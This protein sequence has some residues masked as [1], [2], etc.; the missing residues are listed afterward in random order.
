MAQN[1]LSFG[2][3][4]TIPDQRRVY[5]NFCILRY[6]LIQIAPSN[7]LTNTLKE[8]FAKFPQIDLSAMGFPNG[9]SQKRPSNPD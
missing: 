2:P 6:F 3:G 4:N 1:H 5:Y 8:L 7:D 9:R